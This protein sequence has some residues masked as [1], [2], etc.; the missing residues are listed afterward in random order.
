MTEQNRNLQIDVLAGNAS[1]RAVGLTPNEPVQPFT[2]GTAASWQVVADGVA[3]VHAYLF[4]DGVTLF[5]SCVDPQY[6]V[7]VDDQPVG[8]DWMAVGPGSEILFGSARLGVQ[9]EGVEV[10][11]VEPDPDPTAWGQPRGKPP[12]PSLGMPDEATVMTPMQ[13]GGV[14]PPA[15]HPGSAPVKPKKLKIRQ[16]ARENPADDADATRFAPLDMA[17]VPGAAPTRPPAG[18]IGGEGAL[19]PAASTPPPPR[20]WVPPGV[21]P[22]AIPGGPPMP[23]PMPGGPPMP[24]PMPGG[25]PMPGPAMLGPPVSGPMLGTIPV[26]PPPGA[27]L[28]QE[29]KKNP[30]HTVVEQWKIASIPQKAIIALMPFA[31]ASMFIV[32]DDGDEEEA[33]SP[34]PAVS[35]VAKIPTPPPPPP[36][37]PAQD[38]SAPPVAV[39][40][41]A[42]TEAPPPLPKGQKTL[43]RK[44]AD[45]LA[46]GNDD[47]ALVLYEE[48]LHDQPSNT[49]YQDI[50]R[51]LRARKRK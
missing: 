22:Q 47:A 15:P 25:P 34:A 27:P 16:S 7:Y 26:A 17:S 5:V 1:Q 44:A 18:L 20:A 4:F 29:S 13:A 19:P 23:G 41:D 14:P 50:V 51:I 49:A 43:Q 33:P 30:L 31:F 9:G 39:A 10:M 2:V 36:E 35:S 11:D 32:F 38:A 8:S 46:A 3:E 21:S 42:A 37:V 40:A 28:A 45:A 48:L 12:S 6:P 24:G